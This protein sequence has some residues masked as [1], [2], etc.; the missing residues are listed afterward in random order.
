[1]HAPLASTDAKETP[2]IALNMMVRL[3]RSLNVRMTGFGVQNI[4]IT[5]CWRGFRINNHGCNVSRK[6]DEVVG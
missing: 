3:A 4:L 2:T 1:M 5:C 6:V